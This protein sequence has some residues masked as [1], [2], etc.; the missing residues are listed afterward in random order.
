MTDTVTVAP[1]PLN[2]GFWDWLAHTLEWSMDN[3]AGEDETWWPMARGGIT[4]TQINMGG[5][6]G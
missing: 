6:R 2:T 1:G 5:G 4:I 3:F